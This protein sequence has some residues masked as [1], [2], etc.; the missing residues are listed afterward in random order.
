MGNLFYGIYPLFDNQL[1]I[2]T[3][4][5]LLLLKIILTL[6]SYQYINI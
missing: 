6:F 5:I 3:V 2:L 1:R 4:F